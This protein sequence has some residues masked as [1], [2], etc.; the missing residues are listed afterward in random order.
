VGDRKYGAVKNP[1]RRRGLHAR[2]LSFRH[3]VTGKVLRFESPVPGSF[4]GLFRGDRQ[5]R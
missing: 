5:S 4:P 1:I 2:V 3:P